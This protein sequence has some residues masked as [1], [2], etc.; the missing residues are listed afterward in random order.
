MLSLEPSTLIW[1]VVNILVLY[2]G[3]RKFLFKPVMNVIQQ[4]EDKIKTELGQAKQAQ[5]E[6]EQMK[7][8]YQAKLDAAQQTAEEM[9]VTAKQRAADEQ[10]R[11]L[12]ETR[13]EQNRMLEKAKADIQ[14]EQEKAQM[15]VQ[16]EIA[17]L[18]MSAAR[19]IMKTGEQSDAG[20]N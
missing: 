13:A 2:I 1:T 12:E 15:Q 9:V 17:R 5:D 11:M 10:S 7:A 16:S 3:L 8:T 18:A 14:T 20:S 4:R 6:A 19:K